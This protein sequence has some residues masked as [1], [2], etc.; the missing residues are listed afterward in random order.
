MSCV[1]GKTQIKGV[2]CLFS[3]EKSVSGEICVFN[4]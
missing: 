3:K 4:L 2:E 1:F